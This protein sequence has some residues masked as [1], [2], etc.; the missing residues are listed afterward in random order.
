MSIKSSPLLASFALAIFASTCT[1][2]QSFTPSAVR[3]YPDNPTSGD[4]IFVI[5]NYPC[6]YPSSNAAKIQRIQNQVLVELATLGN[7]CLSSPGQDLNQ[8][9][10]F[11]IGSFGEGDFK[12]AVAHRVTQDEVNF[13][14]Y[15]FGPTL[16]TSF[17]V[18]EGTSDLL[19]GAWVSDQAPGQV[20][21]IYKTDNKT[22]YLNWS[23][24]D[25][26]GAQTWLSAALSLNSGQLAG[27]AQL[28]QGP[29]FGTNDPKQLRRSVWGTLEVQHSGCDDMRLSYS[30]AV[31]GFGV[32]SY[33]FR[34]VV[35]PSGLRKC[36]PSNLRG[37]E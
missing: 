12:V 19:S 10:A 34:P 15:Y 11:S 22:A 31:P 24:F 13:S 28:S 37:R 25:G 35:R 23:T 6:P 9:Y 18:Q 33:N 17:K 4:Q 16:R 32:G 7:V 2:A 29:I 30:S 14:D 27:E 3:I 20:L 26:K 1:L 21:N 8:E 5:V 36:Q